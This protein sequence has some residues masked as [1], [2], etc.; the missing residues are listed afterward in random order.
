MILSL[1]ASLSAL[2]M[3]GSRVPY[4]LSRDRL[5][6]QVLQRVNSGGTPVPALLAGSLLALAFI[7]SNTF[8]TVVSLLA[9][10]FVANYVLT[11]T[12]GVVKVRDGAALRVAEPATAPVPASPV[13]KAESAPAAGRG[14]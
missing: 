14:S 7:A 10:F 6:P 2:L 11:F 12:A 1:V 8:D 3:M 5:F 13:G 9:F 4:A